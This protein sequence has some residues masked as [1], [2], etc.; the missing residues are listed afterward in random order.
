MISIP[1]KKTRITKKKAIRLAVKDYEGKKFLSPLIKPEEKYTFEIREKYWPYWIGEISTVKERFLFKPKEIPFYV[2]CDGITKEQHVARYLP[3][4][5]E[6]DFGS[7]MLIP[8]KLDQAEFLQILQ[9]AR[10]NRIAKQFIFGPPDQVIVRTYQVYIPYWHV[11]I[12]N[13][14]SKNKSSLFI[15]SLSGQIVKLQMEY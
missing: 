12:T 10:K 1:D 11:R 5:L 13:V 15:N 3:N 14:R 8:F 7:H 9:D 2:I 6:I 4:F